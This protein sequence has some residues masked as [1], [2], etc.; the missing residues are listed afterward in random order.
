MRFMMQFPDRFKAAIPCCPMDPIVPIHQ[1]QEKYPGQFAADLAKAFQGK[2]Y[3][4]NGTDMVPSPI[5]TKAFV[6]LPMHFVHAASDQTC[7]IAS[8]YSYIEARKRLGAMDDR[9][10]VY[11]DED[12]AACG[13][14]VMLAHF[15]WVPLLD[16]YSEGSVMR[17]MTGMF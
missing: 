1:V 11:S 10:R 9:L 7:K 15:S 4:W 5:D 2:V 16:D 3:K 14:P 6:A 8:S 17:W 12:M 13:L